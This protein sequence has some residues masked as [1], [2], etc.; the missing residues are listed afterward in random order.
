[1]QTSNRIRVR[2]PS[3][4]GV[5]T[6]TANCNWKQKTTCSNL[7]T[8]GHNLQA[9]TLGLAPLQVHSSSNVK[10][11]E[12]QKLNET[13]GQGKKL[14]AVDVRPSPFCHAQQHYLTE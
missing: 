3:T 11:G 10:Q 7:F 8:S 14:T 6:N 4:P 1:M 9:A 12:G 13:S 5:Y 2:S